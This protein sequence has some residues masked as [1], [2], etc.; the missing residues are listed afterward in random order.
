MLQPGGFVLNKH[1][2]ELILSTNAPAAVRPRGPGLKIHAWERFV[3]RARR[4]TDGF[5]SLETDE[6]TCTI[7]CAETC[8]AGG[9]DLPVSRRV[10]CTLP[11]L[12]LSAWRD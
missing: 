7:M 1:C 4:A 5:G 10:L 11:F 2:E 6:K 8:C 3:D 12:E 9:Q